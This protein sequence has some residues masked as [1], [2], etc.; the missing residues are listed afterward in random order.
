VRADG[1]RRLYRLRENRLAE[2]L[3]MLDNFWGDRLERMRTDLE[4]RRT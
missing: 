4:R 1:N 3:A 2:V